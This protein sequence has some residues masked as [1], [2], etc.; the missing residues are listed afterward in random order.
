MIHLSIMSPLKI[1]LAGNATVSHQPE[2]GVLNFYI[3]N[4]GQDREDVIQNVTESSNEI[5]D[6]FKYLLSKD[7]AG[8]AVADAPVTEFSA[9]SLHTRSDL[10]PKPSKAK[11]VPPLPTSTKPTSCSMHNSETS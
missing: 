5:S 8:E 2:R 4:E 1:T 6:I 3:F 10:Q 9:T 7:E 11:Q